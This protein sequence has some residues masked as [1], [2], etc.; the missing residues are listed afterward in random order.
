MRGILRSHAGSRA[1]SGQ[2]STLR[3]GMAR[4][5]CEVV[6]RIRVRL[7]DRAPGVSIEGTDM[8]SSRQYE[9][10]RHRMLDLGVLRHVSHAPGVECEPLFDERFVARVSEHSPLAKRRSV[11]LKHL[12]D[13]PLLLHERE[14]AALVF[15]K[16]LAL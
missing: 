11:A 8:P 14:Y 4:G 6:N 3:V 10:L 7:V 12:A 1:R 2:A 9:A 15:D 13:E 16:I 5:L